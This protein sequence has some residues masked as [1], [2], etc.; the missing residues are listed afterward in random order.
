MHDTKSHRLKQLI[1]DLEDHMALVR[2]HGLMHAALFLAAAK[3]E[4][5]MH[6]HG[7]SGGELRA[8]CD[9]LDHRCEPLT[10]GPDAPAHVCSA[11]A[12][13]KVVPISLRRR[14]RRA[15]GQVL[16]PLARGP[17]RIA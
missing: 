8:L 9:A 14:H 1:A 10:S 17:I 16:R 13:G 11:G 12:Q 15:G 2:S 5:Q 6:V 7:I 3:L 4:L